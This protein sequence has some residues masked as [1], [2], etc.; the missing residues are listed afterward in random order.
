MNTTA[1]LIEV[2]VAVAFAAAWAVGGYRL[3]QWYHRRDRD[4]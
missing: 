1:I 2:S 4:Q 3:H